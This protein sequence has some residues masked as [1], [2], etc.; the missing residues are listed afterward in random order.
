MVAQLY[1]GS[2]VGGAFPIKQRSAEGCVSMM[3]CQPQT[4]CSSS[5]SHSQSSPAGFARCAMK[6]QLVRCATCIPMVERQYMKHSLEHPLSSS[7]R[8]VG[9]AVAVICVFVVRYIAGL[10]IRIMM[11]M[12]AY[13]AS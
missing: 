3:L 4:T 6:G 11:F 5:S 8:I 2:T 10:C 9:T 7:M 13:A 12:L 1:L